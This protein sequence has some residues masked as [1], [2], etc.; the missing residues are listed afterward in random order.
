MLF[1]REDA[2]R[3]LQATPAKMADVTGVLLHY[4]LSYLLEAQYQP[5][6]SE[7]IANREFSNNSLE[8]LRCQDILP[9]VSSTGSFLGEN[10]I[11]FQSSEQ[12]VSLGLMQ[13]SEKYI[14]RMTREVGQFSFLRNEETGLGIAA[15]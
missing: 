4:H 15:R 2:R 8:R 11:R 6:F 14:R 13:A 1:A 9:E 5:L 12:L 10:S 7:A 3:L